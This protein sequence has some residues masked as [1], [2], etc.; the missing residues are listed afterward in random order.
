MSAPNV[1]WQTNFVPAVTDSDLVKSITDM[2]TG[3]VTTAEQAVPTVVTGNAVPPEGAIAIPGGLTQVVEASIEG[4]LK[5]AQVQIAE[6][7]QGAL[8]QALSGL[9]VPQVATIPSG[10]LKKIDAWERA[11]RTFLTGLVVTVLAGIIQV[12]GQAASTGA[13][14]FSKDGWNAVI[15]LAVGSIVSSVFAYVLRYI[16]EPAGAALDSSTKTG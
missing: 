15:T 7:V 6:R 9:G 11:G 5:A 16:K 3:A 2:V 12:I 10:D 4:A 1:P 14:F 13:D 8:T